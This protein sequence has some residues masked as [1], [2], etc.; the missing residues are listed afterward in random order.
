M[1]RAPVPLAIG[2]L[3]PISS[4]CP[5]ATRMRSAPRAMASSSVV[6][7]STLFVM[8]GLVKMTLP[9]GDVSR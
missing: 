6:A 1:I 7:A 4:G 5:S 8:N 9:P 2:A 3:S